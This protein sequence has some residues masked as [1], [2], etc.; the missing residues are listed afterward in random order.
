MTDYQRAASLTPSEHEL[1]ADSPDVELDN[2]YRFIPSAENFDKNEPVRPPAA[3]LADACETK[4]QIRMDKAVNLKKRK[5]LNRTQRAMCR[6][7]AA[8]GWKAPDIARIFDVSTE[9][10]RRALVNSERYC[11]RPGPDDV[12]KD[13]EFVEDLFAVR[14]PPGLKPH[15][16][17]HSARAF[18]EQRHER[19]KEPYDALSYPT[20]SYEPTSPTLGRSK[21]TWAPASFRFDPI[22]KGEIRRTA[23][24]QFESSSSMP[25]LSAATRSLIQSTSRGINSYE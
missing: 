15:G 13:Y 25:E 5:A 1:L 20:I 12:G 21:S 4:R 3:W 17:A 14:F 10:V 2:R 11:K 7:V 23:S 19:W 18:A 22:S 24:P 8:H 9:P 6:I 16:E